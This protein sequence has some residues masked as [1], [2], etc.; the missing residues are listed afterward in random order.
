MASKPKP[1][2][3][4]VNAQTAKPGNLRGTE[5]TEKMEKVSAPPR[6]RFFLRAS[7]RRMNGDWKAAEIELTAKDMETIRAAFAAER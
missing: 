2:S 3:V 5:S 4:Q 6:Q 1:D 7:C